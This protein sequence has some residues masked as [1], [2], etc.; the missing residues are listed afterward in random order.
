MKNH[1]YSI[2]AKFAF[3]QVI[4]LLWVALSIVLSMPWLKDLGNKIGFIPA[5]IIIAFVAYVPGYLI[6]F[7]VI[8]LLI[9][10]QPQLRTENIK[11]PITVMIAAFNE[12]KIIGETLRHLKNQEYAGEISVLLVNN[13]STDKTAEIAQETAEEIGLKL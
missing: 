11:E 9:D 8:S 5:L 10:R 1:Y 13:N 4:S 7:A 2:N 6:A 3:A 12:E